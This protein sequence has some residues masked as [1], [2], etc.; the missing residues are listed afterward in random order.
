MYEHVLAFIC[1]TVSAALRNG[2]WIHE[3]IQREVSSC[4]FYCVDVILQSSY[5]ARGCPFHPSV[6]QRH[7]AVCGHRWEVQGACLSVELTVR[8]FRCSLTLGLV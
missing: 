5:K 1:N 6:G 7:H 2:E 8:P 4:I 3:Q